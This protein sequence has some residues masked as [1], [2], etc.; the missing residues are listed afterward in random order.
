MA[1]HINFVEERKYEEIE[2]GD[3]AEISKVISEADIV[4]F[5]GITGDFNPIH[6]NPEYAKNTMFGERIAHGMLTA[7]FISTLIGCCIPGKNA[8]YLSQE[9]KFLKPVKIGDVITAKAEVIEKKDEKRRVIIKTT[10][11]NQHNAIVI[12]GEAVA[13]V[14]KD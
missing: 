9:I 2:V 11:L 8:L 7:S 1:K 6:L 14:L 10:I 12:D 5:A 13:M 4:N 3:T